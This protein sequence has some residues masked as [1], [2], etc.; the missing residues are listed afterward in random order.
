[1]GNSGEPEGPKGLIAGHAY[2]LLEL[3]P[4]T[5]I[6]GLRFLKIRNPHGAH[7]WEVPT[8]TRNPKPETRNPKP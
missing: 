4:S 1:M 8:D 3:C 5:T 2:G 7:E 6:V